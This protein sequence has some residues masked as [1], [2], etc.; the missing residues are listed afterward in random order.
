M[1]P[2]LI[3]GIVW[4]GGS[5]FGLACMVAYYSIKEHRERRELE[6]ELDEWIE[7]ALL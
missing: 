3:F 4:I 6:H 1:N 7:K 2:W 5:A